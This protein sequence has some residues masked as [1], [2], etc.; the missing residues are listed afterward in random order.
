MSALQTLLAQFRQHTQT[1]RDKGTAFEHLITLYFQHEPYYQ[2]QYTQVQTYTAWAQ[3]HQ[4]ALNIV[5]I[6]DAGIDLVATTHTG[7][8]HAIQC[9][10]YASDHSIQKADIDSFFTASGKA[11]FSYRIIVTTTNKWS[12]NAREAL[13]NQ[14]P[15]VAVINLEDLENSLIDW[16]QFH[17]D[18]TPVL[19]PKKGLRPHQQTALRKVEKGFAAGAERG[20]LIMACGTGKTFTSLKIAEKLAGAGKRVLFFGTEFVAAQPNL[21]GVDAGQ[22]NILKQFCGLLGFG[23]REE[24]EK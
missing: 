14:N 3:Q 8:Y 7:E 6:N 9:K 13:T 22:R 24:K 21:A 16:T 23:C 15:P 10:N 19:K 1:E 12:K 5:A 11:Y 18:T 4:Q 20:K 2:T 17:I